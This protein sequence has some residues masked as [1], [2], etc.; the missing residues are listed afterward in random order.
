M[1]QVPVQI[2]QPPQCIHSSQCVWAVCEECV[3]CEVC[4]WGVSASGEECMAGEDY[5]RGEE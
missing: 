3:G 4:V 2:T 5:M 1:D